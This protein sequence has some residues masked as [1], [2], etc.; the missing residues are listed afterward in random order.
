[1][2]SDFKLLLGAG[3]ICMNALKHK[4]CLLLH[5]INK[6]CMYM[7]LCMTVLVCVVVWTESTQS[8][9]FYIV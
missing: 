2:Y 7:Y 9:L 8:C 4:I 5:T 6:L 3:L 1:M